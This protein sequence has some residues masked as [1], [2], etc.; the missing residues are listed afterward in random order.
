[1]M[2]YYTRKRR[3]TLKALDLLGIYTV[4]FIL[5]A[6][7]GAVLVEAIDADQEQYLL[8]PSERTEIVARW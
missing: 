7:C 5:F 4:F 3:S 1:M 2:D 6:L 8:S